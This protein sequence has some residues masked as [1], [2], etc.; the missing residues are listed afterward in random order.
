MERSSTAITEDGDGRHALPDTISIKRWFAAYAA[1]YV[2]AA[3]PLAVLIAGQGWTWDDWLHRTAATFA[4]TSPAVKLVGFGL[5]LSM[6]C[7]FCPLPTGWIV[8][9]VATREAAVT[10]ELWTT[11]LAVGAVGALGSTIANLNDYHLF[12]WLLRSKRIAKVRGSRVYRASAEWFGRAPFFILV[13]FNVIPIPVDVIRMLATTYRYPRLRFAA[14]NFVGRFIRYGI[15]AFVTFWWN[16]GWIAVV[17]L[18]GLA[19]VLGAGRVLPALARKLFARRAAALDGP[20][21]KT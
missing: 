17:A 11:V 8:A 18:L 4:A 21:I 20:E 5:Y 19:V 3:V 16:L 14:A 6:C 10:G 9:G 13:V 7:T 12:T 15:I 2:G 1:M